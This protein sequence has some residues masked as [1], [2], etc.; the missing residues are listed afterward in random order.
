M[1][2]TQ[3]I[4]RSP[5]QASTSDPFL[6]PGTTG[7]PLGIPR[8]TD[9]VRLLHGLRWL[10]TYNDLVHEAAG[11]PFT[12]VRSVTPPQVFGAPSGH[13]GQNP[14]R[15]QSQSPNRPTS[16]G[17]HFPQGMLSFPL[18]RPG[19]LSGVRR[20][21]SLSLSSEQ[22]ATT[23]GTGRSPATV[24]KRLARTAHLHEIELEAQRRLRTKAEQMQKNNCTDRQDDDA[25]DPFTPSLFSGSQ[26]SNDH[27]ASNNPGPSP[28]CQT[29]LPTRKD[30]LITRTFGRSSAPFRAQQP[31]NG[32]E[33]E[34]TDADPDGDDPMQELVIEEN[35]PATRVPRIFS[36][37]TPRTWSARRKGRGFSVDSGTA[38]RMRCGSGRT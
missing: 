9:Q 27:L 5:S 7:V 31:D 8:I 20:T 35:R 15:V 37:P 19:N 3:D 21:Q 18:S 10:F 16:K 30:P 14:P 11:L 23:P 38:F 22:L 12:P 33:W 28:D 17:V 6:G 26:H 25:S 34:D 24:M 2:S 1:G 4:T 13:L 32:A 36:P 29:P